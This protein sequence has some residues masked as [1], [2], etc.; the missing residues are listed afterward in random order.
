M[1]LRRAVSFACLGGTLVLVAWVYVRA[2]SPRKPAGTTASAVPESPSFQSAPSLRFPTSVPARPS[3]APADSIPI[4]SISARI[5]LTSGLVLGGTLSDEP[6]ACQTAFGPVSLPLGTIR[7]LHLHETASAADEST[8]IPGTTLS[9]S[10]DLAPPSVG[11]GAST[12]LPAFGSFPPASSIPDTT[13]TTPPGP[14]ATVILANGDSLT[15]TLSAANLRLKTDWGIATI[16]IPHVRSL[17]FTEGSGEA[18]YGWQQHEG[19]WQLH[20]LEDAPTEA[21]AERPLNPADDVPSLRRDESDGASPESPN[22]LA[23][24]ASPRQESLPDATIPTPG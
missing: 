2:Q 16:D 9:P 10:L 24:P 12:P 3:L 8:S 21:P 15:V 4:K 13:S 1:T 5:E 11:P 19:R 17:L 22:E 20:R 6:L 18:A 23:P 7:G 14:T